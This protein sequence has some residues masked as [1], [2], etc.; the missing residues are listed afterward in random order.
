MFTAKP[1]RTVIALVIVLTFGVGATTASAALRTDEGAYSDTAYYNSLPYAIDWTDVAN[2]YGYT[3]SPVTYTIT[4]Q[5]QGGC[6]RNTWYPFNQSVSGSV[7]W[8]WPGGQQGPVYSVYGGSVICASGSAKWGSG[9][10]TNSPPI[11]FIDSD[12][13]G[14]DKNSQFS[15]WTSTQTFP[16]YFSRTRWLYW[17]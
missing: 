3:G 6:I 11:W 7:T 4:G 12:P 9:Q 13:P 14:T 2:Y 1:R 8:Y 5:D 15:Q 10:T 17:N 16:N